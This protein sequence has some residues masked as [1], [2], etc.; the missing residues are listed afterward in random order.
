VGV[1]T[2]GEMGANVDEEKRTHRSLLLLA[3]L[4]PPLSS[5]PLTLSV[6]LS[7]VSARLPISTLSFSYVSALALT[8]LSDASAHSLSASANAA[9]VLH[10]SACRA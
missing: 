3:P 6:R 2:R 9:S 10:P 4:L 8:N 7:S 5:A 1:K